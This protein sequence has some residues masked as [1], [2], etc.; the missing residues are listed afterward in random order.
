MKYKLL[1]LFLLLCAVW[2]F[3]QAYPNQN[4][5]SS[6]TGQSSSQTS[7]SSSQSSTSSG[8]ETTV[9][10]C[11]K[12]S[13]GNYTLTDSSGKTYQLTGDTSKLSDHVGHTVEI[14]G[15]TSSS[16]SNAGT[17]GSAGASSSASEQQSLNVTSMKMISETCTSSH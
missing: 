9:Q 15:T 13:N 5:S 12:G 4:P 17:A 16:S 14:K 7:Q 2:A 8:N 6:Q 11:L 3:A 1:L 10:G